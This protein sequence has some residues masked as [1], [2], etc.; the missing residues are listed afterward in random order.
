M[1]AVY[2]TVGGRSREGGCAPLLLL[3]FS[4]DRFEPEILVHEGDRWR[5]VVL[6]HYTHRK[7]SERLWTRIRFRV[8]F[9]D[10]LIS[11]MDEHHDA[12]YVE[13]FQRFVF[14]IQNAARGE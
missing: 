13:A 10:G 3:T 12:A 7:T 9:R 11:R 6:A 1:G 5:S 8:W 2:R 14:H 4:V